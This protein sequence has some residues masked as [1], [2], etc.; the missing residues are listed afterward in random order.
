MPYQSIDQLPDAVRAEYSTQA[1]EAFLAAFNRA[2]ASCE[3]ED[4]EGRAMGAGHTAA[5]G[6]KSAQAAALKVE[7]LRALNTGQKLLTDDAQNIT[8]VPDTAIPE[9][10]IRH[11]Q[12]A[13]A[14]SPTGGTAD[15]ACS[16]CHWFNGINSCYLVRGVIAPNGLCELHQPVTAEPETEVELEIEG[17]EIEGVVQSLIDEGLIESSQASLGKRIL[18]R[19]K[20][21][22]APAPMFSGS[23]GFK[24][25]SD[26]RWVAWYTNA[27]KDRDGEHFA[28]DAIYQDVQRMWKSRQFPELWFWHIPGTKHGKATWAGT[29]GRFAVAIG[30]FDDTPAA[31]SFKRYYRQRPPELSHGFYFNPKERKD[32][33]YQDYRTFEISTLPVGKAS[34]PLTVFSVKSEDSSMNNL[35]PDQFAELV[36]A[37]GTDE[38]VKMI[39]AGVNAT[40]EA[41]QSFAF[42]AAEE[43][44]AYEKKMDERMSAL[45]EKMDKLMKKMMGE[46]EKPVEEKKDAPAAVTT[47][48]LT[49]EMRDALIVEM[50][51]S[52]KKAASKRTFENLDPATQLIVRSGLGSLIGVK[53]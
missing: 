11:N 34:N 48:A 52:Q 12:T 4:C 49:D 40:K 3:G 41:D 18:A 50:L 2:F 35:T 20:G 5:Q 23:S 9:N 32:G 38:A 14:Y 15:R 6:V 17:D 36:K 25:L 31:Q 24:M 30:V 43:D 29:I 21:M 19:V 22:F 39:A 45:E 46:D 42:K 10:D 33:V 26:N 8:D 7:Q 47:P 1:Q 28:T 13:V 53:E 44:K 51:D 16:S 37:V 27:Y